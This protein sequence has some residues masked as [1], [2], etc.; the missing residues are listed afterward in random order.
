MRQDGLESL[1]VS[2]CLCLLM[3]KTRR[4]L[5]GIKNNEGSQGGANICGCEMTS[6]GGGWVGE[7]GFHDYGFGLRL[8]QAFSLWPV[9]HLLTDKLSFEKK[10][11]FVCLRVF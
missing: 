4:F 6:Q 5:K 1:T 3:A 7:S 2:S 11:F 9:R 10:C 8:T